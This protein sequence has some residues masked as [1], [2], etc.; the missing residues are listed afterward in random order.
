MVAATSFDAADE[1]QNANRLYEKTIQL[2]TES[3]LKV[4]KGIFGACMQV[5]S[6][7]PEKSERFP[8]LCPG[9]SKGISQGDGPVTF[10]LDSTEMS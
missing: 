10:L 4:E 2:V 9:N 3:G 1:P 6:V 8:G 5:A 7:N